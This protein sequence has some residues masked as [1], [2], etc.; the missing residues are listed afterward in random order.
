[1]GVWFSTLKEN[2]FYINFSKKINRIKKILN[3]WLAR[4]LTLLGK[5]TIIKSVAVSQ[6]LYM[7]YPLSQ[8]IRVHLKKLI[9]CCMIS[10]GMVKGK[11]SKGQK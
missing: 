8:L 3:S 1:M 4:R 5:T 7:F 11:K 9:P 2:A 6:L 10:S